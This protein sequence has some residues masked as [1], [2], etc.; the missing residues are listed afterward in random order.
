V[1]PTW[2]GVGDVGHSAP[3]FLFHFD[4]T[5]EKLCNS[6]RLVA[7]KKHQYTTKTLAKHSVVVFH[8]VKFVVYF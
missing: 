7:F 4:G 3:F 8:C 1:R 5:C 6:L 2:W